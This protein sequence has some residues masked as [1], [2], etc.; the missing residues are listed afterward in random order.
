MWSTVCKNG[1]LEV[2]DRLNDGRF[3]SVG[4]VIRPI[5]NSA[6]ESFHQLCTEVL[7]FEGCFNDYEFLMKT[8]VL[9]PSVFG[10]ATTVAEVEIWEKGCEEILSLVRLK[11]AVVVIKEGIS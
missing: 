7:V 5:E 4:F 2:S 9:L 11:I 6:S 1:Y 3:K 10:N 8:L